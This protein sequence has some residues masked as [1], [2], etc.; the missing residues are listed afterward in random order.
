M[1]GSIPALPPALQSLRRVILACWYGLVAIL[2]MQNFVGL[3]APLQFAFLL[4][5]VQ[6]VPLLL[7]IR[8]LHKT[9]LRSYAWFSFLILLYFIHGVLVSFTP[10][11]LLW[12]LLEVTACVVLFVALILFIR[13]YREHFN[14]GL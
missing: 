10:G 4:S 7:F 12:G 6:L 3:D 1:N 8:G 14:V 13:G 11:R 2:L 9:R 5:L